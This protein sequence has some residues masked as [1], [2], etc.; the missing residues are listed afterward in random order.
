[1]SYLTSA[2]FLIRGSGVRVPPRLP[3]SSYDFKASS[4]VVGT[5]VTDLFIVLDRLGR[6]A[7]DRFRQ[8]ITVSVGRRYFI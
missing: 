2:R 5:N 7:G 4:P 8:S 3:I 1:M 6:G